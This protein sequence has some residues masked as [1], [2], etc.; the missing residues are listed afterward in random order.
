VA[1]DLTPEEQH[2]SAARNA[3]WVFGRAC[4]TVEEHTPDYAETSLTSL[5]NDLMTELWDNG[6]SSDEISSA[7]LSAAKDVYRYAGQDKRNGTGIRGV[8]LR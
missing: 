1:D 2:L 3:A 4:R 5:V 7:M 8:A 6:F